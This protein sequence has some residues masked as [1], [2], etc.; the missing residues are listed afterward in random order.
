MLAVLAAAG[1]NRRQRW[2]PG[3]KAGY[4]TCKHKLPSQAARQQVEA[5]VVGRELNRQTTVACTGR[6]LPAAAGLQVE[7][8]DSRL[9]LGSWVGD[10][11]PK[12]WLA[13]ALHSP[14]PCKRLYVQPK[15]SVERLEYKR[16]AEVAVSGCR[17][18]GPLL[19][20][21]FRASDGCQPGAN[22]ELAAVAWPSGGN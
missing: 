16:T 9:R 2:Q 5:R 1:S 6:E 20:A 19:P 4:R 11:K 12:A 13:K 22:I 8:F 3:C 21:F 18:S 10:R 17:S 7:V 14:E 15:S